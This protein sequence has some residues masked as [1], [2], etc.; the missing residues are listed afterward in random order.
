MKSKALTA[1]LSLAG[2]ILVLIWLQGGFHSKVPGGATQA[3]IDAGSNSSNTAKAELV[4]TAASVT[5]SGNVVSRDMARIASRILGYVLELKVDAGDRVTKGQRLIT[6][7]TKEASEKLDQAKAALESA[8]A[9]FAK[10]KTDLE[11]YKQLYEKQSV[12][13]KDYDD[14]IT[15]FEVT[16]AAEQRAQSA[17]EEAETNL[18]YG[19]VD[20]PF[21]GIVSERNVNVGDLATPGKPLLSV[22]KQGTLE[23]ISAIGEQYAGFLHPGTKVRIAISSL[24]LKQDSQIREIVPQRDE[25]TR[26]ITVKAPLNDAPGL[27]PGLYGTLTFDTVV[28]K[29][30]VIPAAAVKRVG[31]LETVKVVKE[32]SKSVR[33]VKTGRE[34]DGKIEVISGLEV[35]ETVLVK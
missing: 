17:V 10:A 12:A 3:K 28:S 20:A 21:D 4:D 16:K 13:K 33:H 27:G 30:V 35:G 15:R 7:D 23:L 26:T 18:A 6:I 25:K 24:D 11:R 31:Q 22:Y 1:A 5:V 8:K 9:D 32:G 14:A 19:N 34:I 29:A 2:L